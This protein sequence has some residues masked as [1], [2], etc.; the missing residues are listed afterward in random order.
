MRSEGR[1]G[2]ISWLKSSK[3]GWRES[4]K[5]STSPKSFDFVAIRETK[6]P[7][8]PSCFFLAAYLVS[9]WINQVEIFLTFLSFYY[10][11]WQIVSFLW[12]KYF[13]TFYLINSSKKILYII[14]RVW[15]KFERIRKYIYTSLEPWKNIS[16]NTI[17][18]KRNGILIRSVRSI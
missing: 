9:F 12:K 4:R 2:K 6:F 18:S 5:L 3:L 11:S 16:I 13:E 1:E 15:N 14:C 7:S 8:L 17:D 10:H